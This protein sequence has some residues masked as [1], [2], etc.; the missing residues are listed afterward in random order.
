MRQ[1]LFEEE[2]QPRWQLLEA[3]ASDRP[4]KPGES[5]LDPADLPEAYRQLCQ[6]LS[7]AKARSYS[8]ELQQRLEDL[9]FACHQKLHRARPLFLSE[10]LDFFNWGLAAA[11][12]REWRYVTAAG[13]LFY[14]P[15]LI[16]FAICWFFP[17]ACPELVPQSQLDQIRD[18][19]DPA[20]PHFQKAREAQSDLAMWG[21]YIWNNVSIDFRCFALGALCGLGSL[22]FLGFNGLFFGVIGA[23]LTSEGCGSTFWPFVCGHGAPELT[24]LVLSGAAGFRLGSSLL[25]PGQLSRGQAF[26]ASARAATPLIL[27]AALLTAFAAFIEAFWSPRVDISPAIKYGVAAILWVGVHLYLLQPWRRSL[28]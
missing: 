17:Q 20:A 26:A 1:A 27:G 10:I 6:D 4:S 3:L 22:F 12:R 2:R 7:L 15:L 19:Y 13:A 14:A 23:Y 8:P 25:A 9:A 24:G 18:M 11:L 5:T 28:T 21:F 16:G